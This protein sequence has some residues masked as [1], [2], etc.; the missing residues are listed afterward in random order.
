M[1]LL[2]DLQIGVGIQLVVLE[3]VAGLDGLHQA[4]VVRVDDGRGQ[5]LHHGHGDERGVHD[6]ADVL[7]CAVGVVGQTAGGLQ[8][9][10]REQLDGVQNV[11]LLVL[12]AL[13][14]QEQRV[15]PQIL[16]LHAQ[17]H[18]AIKHGMAVVHTLVIVLRNAVGGAEGEQEGRG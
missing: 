9:L 7:R 17:R 1:D 12:H 15:E 14:D 10:V 5:A 18:A 3:D 4:Q 2:L 8:A 13:D 6:R 11:H 16:G